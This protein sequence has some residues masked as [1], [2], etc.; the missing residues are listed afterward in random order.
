MYRKRLKAVYELLDAGNN[1]KVIQEVEK[2]L[3]SAS[4]SSK[5]PVVVSSEG[6][7]EFT[8]FTIAKALKSLALLRT[9]RKQES[10]QLIDE[11]L[12]TNTTDENALSIIMQYCKETQQL[13]K[14]VTFYENAANKCQK[15]K[16][17][18]AEHEEILS[19]LF[20]AYARNRDYAKQQQV[21]MKLYKLTNKMMYTFWNAASYVLMVKAEG[22]SSL[23]E[24]QKQLYLQLAEKILQ[25]AYD[26]K[27]T[28]FDGEFLLFLN[29]LEWRGKHEEA[30]CIVESLVDTNLVKIGQIN[31]KFE[32][33]ISYL[34]S[35]NKWTE[36]RET[37]EAYFGQPKSSNLDDW[38][39]Y[40]AYFDALTEILKGK[41][42]IL[43]KQFLAYYYF[44][45]T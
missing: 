1:K 45:A 25:K 4:S 13:Q 42:L 44:N 3:S 41:N 7:D 12:D 20:Y 18:S 39:V 23:S 8:T 40:L 21:A 19:S 11:L 35:M 14:I 9:G 28:E 5:K 43:N 16:L 26:D 2:L 30:L 33:K 17:N 27:K 10:D 22:V 36:V 29:I 38:P 24:Q 15:N 6:Y 32:K 31:F 34:K 37:C